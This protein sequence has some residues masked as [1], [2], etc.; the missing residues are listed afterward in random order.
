MRLPAGFRSFVDAALMEY[1]VL[2]VGAGV[3]GEEIL[4]APGDLVKA[5]RAVI[6]NLTEKGKPVLPAQPRP[7]EES[8]RGSVLA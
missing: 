6:V 2:G 5:S 7:V 8:R 4:L 1:E 3:C